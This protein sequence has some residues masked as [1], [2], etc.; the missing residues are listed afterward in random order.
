MSDPRKLLLELGLSDAEVRVYLCLMENGA[1][2]A[3]EIVRQAHLKR[4][5]AYYALRQLEDRGLVAK[6][7]TPGVERFQAAPAERLLDLLD[8]QKAALEDLRK[9][10]E[11]ILPTL[12]KNTKAREGLPAVSFFEGERAMQQAIA[13]SLYCRNATID[14]LTPHNN[15]FWQTTDQAWV[16]SYIGERKRRGIH[17]RHLWE[18]LLDPKVMESYPTPWKY[19][20]LLPESMRGHFETTIL[21]FDDKVMYV[22]SKKSG[23]VL[24]VRS[25][26]HHDVIAAMFEALWN[27]SQPVEGDAKKS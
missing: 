17:T 11:T 20:R 15:F 21:L 2:Q 22:S 26:E 5:T 24:V 3:S 18:K 12:P 23:Y 10:T 7:G 13:E 1:L 25:K 19:I 8:H 4:P 14:F 16:R 6:T 27:V 9:R